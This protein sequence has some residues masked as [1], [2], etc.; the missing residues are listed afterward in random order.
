MFDILDGDK[1]KALDSIN[2]TYSICKIKD[3]WAQCIV[4]EKKGTF[5]FFKKQT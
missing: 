4:E 5:V 1:L 3:V 2:F